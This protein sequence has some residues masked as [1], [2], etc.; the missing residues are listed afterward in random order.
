MGTLPEPA[1]A[2]GR[3]GLTALRGAPERALVAVDFDGT[4]APIVPD[5][6][7]AR[8]H[9]DALPAL[10][11]LAAR[12]GTLAVITGRSAAAVVRLGGFDR[13]PGLSG[14]TVLGAYGAERWDAATGEFRT[15][16]P[17]PGVAAAREA[18]PGLLAECGAADAHIEDKG[19]AVAVHTRRAAEPEASFARLEEPL[20]SLAARLGLTL[21]PGRLVLELRPPGMDKGAALTALVK[22]TG[23]RSVLYAGDDLGDL[24]AFEAVAALRAQGVPGVRVCSASTEV[25]RLSEIADLTV[26]GPAGVAALLAA[27]AAAV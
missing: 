24:A 17:H 16:P 6:E 7:Q 20:G 21:E 2:E 23:A 9:P 11:R 15:P 4:L 26:D 25:T 5:P 8:A 3:D 22:E 27:L 19:G 1:T 12:V 18:L 14:L 10:A 13:H